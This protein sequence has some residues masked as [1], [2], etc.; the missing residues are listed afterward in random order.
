MTADISTDLSAWSATAGSNQP[1]Y[2]DAVG[3]NNLADNLRAIQAAVRL[4]QSSSTIASAGTCDLSTVASYIL[5]VTGTTTITALG[6][7]SAGVVKTL[8]FAGALTFTHNGTSLILPTAANITTVADDVAIVL[9]LGSGNWRC[10]NYFRK[11][12][13]P[14]TSVSSFGD[15]TV[16][17]P[18]I[19][20][21]SDTDSGLYRI[22]AN[23][24][25]LAV[26]G[27]KVVD[28]ATTGVS[29][30]GALS[31][32]TTVTAG[33]TFDGSVSGY[34][35]AS[36]VHSWS[37]ATGNTSF[38]GG[39]S[40]DGLLFTAS[41]TAVA[42]LNSNGFYHNGVIRSDGSGFSGYGADA[43]VYLTKSSATPGTFL[44][45]FYTVFAGD[46]SRN[47]I[48]LENTGGAFFRVRSD[49]AVFAD[50]AYSGAGADFAEWFLPVA[51]SSLTA[52]DAVSIENGRVKLAGP[53][54][55]PIG[56]ISER[57]AVIGDA[58]LESQGGVLVGLVGKL[59]VKA[60]SPIGTRWKFLE[61]GNGQNRYLVR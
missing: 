23:N 22:G 30:T 46:T 47:A 20:F 6:T 3:P 29:V 42:M 17:A 16:G 43:Q 31:A 25:G 15:G 28:V 50:G 21:T 14:L 48:Y 59:W 33:T 8:I 57:P 2:T 52:G 51:G 5:T 24:V 11:T 39:A 35:M 19:A 9:S 55:D 60:G 38:I 37:Y 58:S 40:A 18:S 1:D 61:H 54:D 41:S 12:G 49:G 13:S 34:R 27:A 56:V 45:G 53:H 7:M 44:S 4:M 10:I 36:G 32:S 26:N